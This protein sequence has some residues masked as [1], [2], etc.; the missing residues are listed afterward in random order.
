M[1]R[2]GA[3]QPAA[4]SES[5]L[6]RLLGELAVGKPDYERMTPEIAN[7]VRAVVTL[8]QQ[9]L[10]ALGPVVSTSFKRTDPNGVDTYHVVFR[11]GAAD[12]EISL[13]RQGRSSTRSISRISGRV[14]TGEWNAAFSAG[15][16]SASSRSLSSRPMVLSLS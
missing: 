5:A 3:Q 6:R 16:S 10:S 8:D 14:G 1:G 4:D 7:A 15:C 12:F 9:L 2:A 13:K 11:N